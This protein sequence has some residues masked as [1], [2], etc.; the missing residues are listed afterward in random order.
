MSPTWVHIVHLAAKV[1]EH[2][3]EHGRRKE[4]LQESVGL[5]RM[6]LNFHHE[7]VELRRI[8]EP[9]HCAT[10]GDRSGRG[11]AADHALR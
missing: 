4:A 10:A 6:V 9:S 1:Y 8:A 2:H 11:D 5:A 3:G 7:I